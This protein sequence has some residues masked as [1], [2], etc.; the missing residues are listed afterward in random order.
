M[1]VTPS[2]LAATLLRRAAA[3]RLADASDEER[4]R[5]E[6]LRLIPALRRELGFRRAWLI[7]TLAWGGF[8]VRSDIDVVLEGA[9]AKVVRAV[10]ERLGEA[11]GREVDVL[12][13]DTVPASFKERIVK[14]GLDVP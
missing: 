5:A 1:S 2:E 13:L 12:V 4:C 8:G 7:G 6:V 14:D 10:A 11:T 9:D 3:R